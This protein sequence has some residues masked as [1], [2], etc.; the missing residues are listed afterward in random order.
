MEHAI[1]TLQK[2]LDF[3]NIPSEDEDEDDLI[4]AVIHFRKT[5]DIKL[6]LKILNEFI[7]NAKTLSV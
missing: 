7:T 2:E 3:L 4:D 5:S 1:K 6:A